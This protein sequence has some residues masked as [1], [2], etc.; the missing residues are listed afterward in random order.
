MIETNTFYVG[1]E[2]YYGQIAK[3]SN[4]CVSKIDIGFSGATPEWITGITI[5]STDVRLMIASLPGSGATDSR[6]CILTAR[7]NVDTGPIVIGDKCE[8]A[9]KIIQSRTKYDVPVDFTGT[10]NFYYECSLEGGRTISYE[11]GEVT[12][13]CTITKKYP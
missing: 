8:Y 5:G 11:G 13:G 6:E 2:G 4:N 9:V 12:I 3:F 1:P 7:T 10:T